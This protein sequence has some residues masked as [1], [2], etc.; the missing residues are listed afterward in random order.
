MRALSEQ[1][2]KRIKV[3]F[4]IH[5]G[6]LMKKT[7][8]NT[9]G[10]REKAKV[11]V[12][13]I[14]DM[15]CGFMIASM[16]A[17]KKI[18]KALSLPSD[19]RLFWVL[20]RADYT[21]ALDPDEAEM[22]VSNFPE[23]FPEFI[24]KETVKE[25]PEL[26]F[27]DEVFVFSEAVS[28]E[29]TVEILPVLIENNSGNGGQP[30]REE[31]DIL[32]LDVSSDPWEEVVTKE[33]MTMAANSDSGN[34]DQ[35]KEVADFDDLDELDGFDDEYALGSEG[36]PDSNDLTLSLAVL[37][38]GVKTKE[39]GIME[40]Q[41]SRKLRKRDLELLALSEDALYARKWEKISLNHTKS[42]EVEL[43]D[44]SKIVALLCGTKEMRAGEPGRER[45]FS[46]KAYGSCLDLACSLCW[47]GFSCRYCKYFK[48]PE[49]SLD[50]DSIEVSFGTP[51]YS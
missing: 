40:F 44:G 2:L 31:V 28:E 39:K 8:T 43:F 24:A 7:K 20:I 41:G 51:D 37:D 19:E 16:S 34:S 45:Y 1:E 29:M 14:N 35:L 22:V 50:R 3:A 47:D 21:G 49:M 18:A 11:S 48:D 27:E 9:Q 26:V 46:C 15:L 12:E 36:E 17:G 33:L 32:H 30:K 38:K 13:Y 25:D 42:L 4:G 5:L 6:G 10:L 23:L